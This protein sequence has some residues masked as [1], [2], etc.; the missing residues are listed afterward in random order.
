[1]KIGIIGKGHVGTAIGKGLSSN[2]HLVMYGHR[3]PKEPVTEVAAWGEII[4]L[5]VPHESVKSVA[6]EIASLVEGKILLDATNAVDENWNLTVGFS[7]S[8]AEELQK[9][10][11]KTHVVKAFNTVF[12]KNQETGKIGQNPLTLFVAGDDAEAKEII[13][14]LGSEIGFE[15]LDAGPLKS[16]RYLEP[17]A[18]LLMTLAFQLGMGTEIG[19]KL[20]KR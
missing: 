1:L 18:I 16:A 11:P 20:V 7:T 5:A 4:V 12:A 13:M 15:S 8:A 6:N 3:D 2:G 14:Q 19:F 9:L 10:L 17:M